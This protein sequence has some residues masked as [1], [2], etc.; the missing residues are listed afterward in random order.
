MNSA[1]SVQLSKINAHIADAFYSKDAHALLRTDWRS[2][3]LSSTALEPGFSDFV[4]ALPAESVATLQR[5]ASSII[6]HGGEIFLAHG[7][8]ADVFLVAHKVKVGSGRTENTEINLII[9]KCDA[10]FHNCKW[11]WQKK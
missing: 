7:N 10:N 2:V 6:D 9:C 1:T 3:I 8:D 11:F 4:R 5:L